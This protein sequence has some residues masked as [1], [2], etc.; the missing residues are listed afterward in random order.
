[1]ETRLPKRIS[2]ETL[3]LPVASFLVFALLTWPVW[4]WLWQEWMGNQYYSHGIL[5]PLVTLFLMVQRW[6]NDESFHWQQSISASRLA[7]VALAI[8]VLLY[9][10]AFNGKAFYIAA[11][12]M[13]GIIASL[14][15][16]FGGTNALRRLAFPLA[17]LILMIPLPFIESSTLPLAMFTG[18]CS[19]GLVQFLGLDVNIVGNAVTLPNADL[20]IGAQCSGINSLIAL[21]ALTALAA[22]ILKGPLWG[23]VLLV[24]LAIPLA[25]VSNILRVSS[26][27]FVARQ[28][29]AEAGFTFYHDYSG[30]VFFIFALLL[31]YPLAKFLR[32]NEL[33]MD[34][35]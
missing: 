16:T 19:G 11:I 22:Y 21:T 2:V 14:V 17:Y 5:I 6:R 12:F 18:V 1:M 35:I 23:K 28:F 24:L 7:L 32:F 4:R 30:P 34:V 25:M 15:W 20:V 33:R 10:I 27:L 29:G 26:L 8:F 31:L 13:T 3:A 9:L